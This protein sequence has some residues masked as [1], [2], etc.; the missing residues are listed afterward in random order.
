MIPGDPVARL[1]AALRAVRLSLGDEAYARAV[2]AARVA[3]GRAVL[4]GAVN[5][6]AGREKPRRP[7]R[8]FQGGKDV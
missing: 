5:A 2:T 8:K 1:L 3:V 7:S 6:S 4:A